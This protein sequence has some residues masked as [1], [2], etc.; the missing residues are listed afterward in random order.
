MK[1]KTEQNESYQNNMKYY[2]EVTGPFFMPQ[3]NVLRPSVRVYWEPL[4][5]L[6]NQS[7]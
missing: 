3:N 4:F 5:G 6:E 1:R 7:S 2:G